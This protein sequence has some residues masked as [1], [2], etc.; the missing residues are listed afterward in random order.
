[1]AG[2][3]GLGS[4]GNGVDRQARKGMVVHAKVRNGQAGTD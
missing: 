3:D 4:E 2:M 1:M